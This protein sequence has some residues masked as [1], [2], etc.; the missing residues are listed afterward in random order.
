MH[1]SALS[2]NCSTVHVSSENRISVLFQYC[3]DISINSNINRV[4]VLVY[5][6]SSHHQIIIQKSSE[7]SRFSFQKYH[8]N[9]SEATVQLSF[10]PEVVEDRGV[11]VK[12]PSTPSRQYSA[13][14]SG[15][16]ISSRNRSNA[17]FITVGFDSRLLITD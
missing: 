15:P 2:S 13:L 10:V 7:S 14:P 5:N 12:V 11:N 17:A 16:R 3:G 1:S 9:L 6:L 4:A 8:A